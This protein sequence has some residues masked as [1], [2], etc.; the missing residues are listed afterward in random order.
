MTETRVCIKGNGMKHYNVTHNWRTVASFALRRILLFPAP[1][2]FVSDSSSYMRA[3][4]VSID[5]ADDTRRNAVYCS[6]SRGG[7]PLVHADPVVPF[8]IEAHLDR[9]D[10]KLNLSDSFVLTYAFGF[11]TFFLLFFLQIF[12]FYTLRGGGGGIIYQKLIDNR[13]YDLSV[14]L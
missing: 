11:C 6:F 1:L 10:P 12:L 5:G 13:L 7:W 14:L 8:E 9:F 3:A 2:R 4:S